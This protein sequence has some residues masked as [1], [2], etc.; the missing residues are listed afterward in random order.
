MT[1]ATN[2]DDV[3]DVFEDAP[4]VD[5]DQSEDIND[6]SENGDDQEG[7][8]EGSQEDE[9]DEYEEDGKTYKIPK[10]LKGHLLRNKDYTQKTQE[11]AEQRRAFEAE[12]VKAQEDAKEV[13]EAKFSYRGVQ[14]RLADLQALTP[15]DW[16]QVR[17]LDQRNGTNNYDK[18]QR[19]F[20][21]LP[22]QADELKR[23]LDQ[24]IS[25]ARDAQQQT[26]AQQVA[27]GQAIL[28]RDIPG[29]GPELGAK[30]VEFVKSEYGVTEEKHGQAFMDPALVKLAHAA[31]KAKEA[32]RKTQTQ[33]RADQ[34]KKAVPANVV[35]GGSTPKAGAHDKLSTEE[36]ARRRNQELAA[37]GKR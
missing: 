20:L 14:N 19:E 21:T 27:Q 2:Q 26:V 13:E 8:D 35:K 1:E 18:L 6:Q 25:E 32:S 33:Q 17:I 28:A 3:F 15:D 37:K 30:L 7:D 11:L 31:Y 36:F 4:G 5:D 34:A 24:K 16:D 12:R 29:W 9:L 22:R 10:D 23:T